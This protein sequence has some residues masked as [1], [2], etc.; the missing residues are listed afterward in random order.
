M[1]SILRQNEKY[2]KFIAEFTALARMGENV[3]LD[4]SRRLGRDFFLQDV[5]KEPIFKVE[6]IKIEA[7]DKH[8]I[9]VRIFRPKEGNL[10][11]MVYFHRGG[12][13]FGSVAEADPVCRKLANHLNCVIASVDYRLAPEHPFPTPMN[14]A[15][16]AT[17]GLE[18]YAKDA[19][20]FVVCGESAG[21]N[22]AAAV[23][24]LARDKE[25]PKI[26]LQLLIY[27]VIKAK[28][29]DQAYE[30]SED[31]SFLTK[32]TMNFFWSM[33]LQN[34][35]DERAPYS[36]LDL[37]QN[38]KDLPPAIVITAEY[39]PLRFEA[40]D[41][42][43]KLKNSGNAVILKEV[44]KVIHGFI[45][46]PIYTYEEKIAWIQEINNELYKVLKIQ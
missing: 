26:D 14:D 41:Y 5:V 4:E 31:K 37:S 35:G 28:A 27:P 17:V 44:P 12:F 25:G 33:Y 40:Q 29:D 36:S 38:L 18:K 22:L 6:D 45:D 16:D 13:V 43:Q 39:D 30:N 21:G 8:Q 24:L 10:P 7:R 46:M 20:S 2:N 42:A 34:P 19:S 1:T 3:S 9:P 11:F 15:Y 23:S 32:D